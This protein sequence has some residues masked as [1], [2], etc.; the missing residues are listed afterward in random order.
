M[1]G[2][3]P[4]HAPYSSDGVTAGG[5]RLVRPSPS[6]PLQ[7]EGLSR[8]RLA[9]RQH[10]PADFGTVSGMRM[11]AV[12]EGPLFGGLLAQMPRQ[13]GRPQPQSRAPASLPARHGPADRA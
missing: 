9:Q 10:A 3:I 2:Y 7:S 1:G 11:D 13:Q 12:E 6:R 5:H 8:L 4:L